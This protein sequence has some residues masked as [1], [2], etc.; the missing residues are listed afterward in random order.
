MLRHRQAK[1]QAACH[2][3]ISL[4]SLSSS[5]DAILEEEIKAEGE[6]AMHR[7]EQATERCELARFEVTR[8][9]AESAAM[10]RLRGVES[11]CT[12]LSSTLGFHLMASEMLRSL[13]S[14]VAL[15]QASASEAHS[16]LVERNREHQDQTFAVTTHRI[17][18]HLAI[19]RQAIHGGETEAEALAKHSD[20]EKAGY[21]FESSSGRW[22]KHRGW[23][24]LHGGRLISSS[25][26][27]PSA[28]RASSG[29][30][31]H[32]DAIPVNICTVKEDPDVPL[33]FEVIS[34]Q[35]TRRFQAA[36]HI[37]MK[38]WTI[39]L[40]NAIEAPCLMPYLMPYLVDPS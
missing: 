3:D 31:H 1:R 35:G 37:E 23:V 24:V 13:Q 15:I 10:D 26:S 19:E 9:V 2:D 28:S 16:Q 14:E 33:A 32:S 8:Q 38:Q 36:S 21:L 40:R 17:T 4:S 7:V 18:Q 39:A 30:S 29:S 20:T 12:V 6:E 27:M 25:S 34:P 5:P 22:G 11:F